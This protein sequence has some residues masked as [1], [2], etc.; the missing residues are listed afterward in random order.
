MLYVCRPR[1]DCPSLEESN[2]EESNA[3]EVRQRECVQKIQTYRLV[4]EIMLEQQKKQQQRRKEM[5]TLQLDMYNKM[6]VGVDEE[7]SM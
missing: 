7:L 3:E 2:A 5:T 1:K 6:E 4:R